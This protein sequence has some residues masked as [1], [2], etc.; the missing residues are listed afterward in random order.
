MYFRPMNKVVVLIAIVLGFSACTDANEQALKRAKNV[1]ASAQKFSDPNTSVVALN[2][3]I[4]LDPE[5]LDYKDSLCRIYLKGGNSK[6]GIVLAEQIQAS[7][8]LDNKMLELL[9]VAYQETKKLDKASTVFTNLFSSTNDYRYIYQVTAIAYEKNNKVEFDSLAD[10]ML[11]DAISD[12]TIASTAIDFPGPLSGQPQYIPLDAATLFLK[13]KY[14]MDKEGDINTAVAY[15]SQALG[16][17]E[18]FELPYYYLQQIEQ[19]SQ[20]RR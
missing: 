12:S 6:G 5:N 15:Y 20:G 3:L 11:V 10:K 4:L 17:Y 19:M 14:A 16:K 13:G 2:Q 9:G 8:T 18:S 7:K 1:Y